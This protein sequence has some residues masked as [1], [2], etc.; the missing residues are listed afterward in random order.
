[1]GNYKIPKDK[2]LLDFLGDDLITPGIGC[3]CNIC[4]DENGNLLKKNYLGEF[5]TEDDKK[6]ARENLGITDMEGSADNITYET[7]TDPAI[8][9]VRDA[10]DKLFYVP[11]TITS[12]TVVPTEAETGELVN[13][14]VYSWKYNKDITSQTLD[15]VEIEKSLRTET[16]NGEFKT[17]TT[18]TLSVSDGSTNKSASATL[19]FKDGRYY[20][21]S[22]T[23]PTIQDITSS[24]T[25]SLNLNRGNS[26][27]VNARDGQYIYLLVPYSLKNISFLVGGFEGGFYIVNDNYQFTKYPGTSIR[28]VLFRSD[29]PGLGSTTVTIK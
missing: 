16:I 10:L 11:L 24:F 25:R 20:G 23:D 17:N 28:C 8:E 9:T 12:F 6:K 22:E 27:T 2:K 13:S 4:P 26:F 18:K 21:V 15:G 3:G 1:M 29:N 19:T 7:P 14:L 5:L